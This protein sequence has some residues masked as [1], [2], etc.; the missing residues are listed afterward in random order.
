LPFFV[1]FIHSIDHEYINHKTRRTDH[2]VHIHIR[3]HIYIYIYRSNQQ[4]TQKVQD[5]QKQ[6]QQ[7]EEK[8]ARESGET[9][10]IHMTQLNEHKRHIEQLM[11]ENEQLRHAADIAHAQSTTTPPSVAL[12]SEERE[13]F[14]KEII[15]LRQTSDA[16]QQRYE[17]KDKDYAQL[18]QQLVDVNE[19][20]TKKFTSIEVLDR[21]EL[22]LFHSWNY[23]LE[24]VS[25]SRV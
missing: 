12:T 15:Q 14:E 19:Q 25:I 1:F 23:L 3:I 10:T 24:S 20:Y 17:Q 6:F 7:N 21:V 22:C 4:L 5:V 18:Q 2:V 11:S 9:R 16:H 8:S 13:Q